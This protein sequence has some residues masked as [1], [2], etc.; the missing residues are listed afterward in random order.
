M[1]SSSW[2]DDYHACKTCHNAVEVEYEQCD[3]CEYHDRV[4]QSLDVV[5]VKLVIPV[6]IFALVV[7]FIV[8]PFPENVH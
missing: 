5:L 7:F 1:S 3:D 2:L 8:T 6:I 4:T